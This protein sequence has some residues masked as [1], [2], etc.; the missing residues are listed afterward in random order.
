MPNGPTPQAERI[1]GGTYAEIRPLCRREE[2][3]GRPEEAPVPIGG[4]LCQ[5]SYVLRA[6]EEAPVSGGGSSD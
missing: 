1:E 3:L 5:R 2:A 4:P 6:L